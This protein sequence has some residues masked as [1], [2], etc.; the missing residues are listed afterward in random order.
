MRQDA[1]HFNQPPLPCSTEAPGCSTKRGGSLRSK[2]PVA[3][4]SSSWS[5]SSSRAVN[6]ALLA[7]GDAGTWGISWRFNGMSWVARGLNGQW[8]SLGKV[9]CWKTRL[10]SSNLGVRPDLPLIKPIRGEREVRPCTSPDIQALQS[11]GFPLVDWR[12]GWRPLHNSKPQNE[13]N[14]VHLGIKGHNWSRHTPN[15][16]AHRSRPMHLFLLASSSPPYGQVSSW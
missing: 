3:N 2:G 9:D 4:R 5:S 15:L 6:L 16:R 13:R 8:M 1:C 12:T 14:V 11:T 7:G 10:L